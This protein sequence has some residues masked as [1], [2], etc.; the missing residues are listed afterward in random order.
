APLRLPSTSVFGLVL[1]HDAVDP[2]PVGLSLSASVGMDGTTDTA[3]DAGDALT[4]FR[5]YQYIQLGTHNR[6]CQGA[7]VTAYPDGDVSS[8]AGLFLNTAGLVTD[9]QAQSVVYV[10]ATAFVTATTGT[11]DGV[12]VM[13]APETAVLRDV[14]VVYD[15]TWNTMLSPS[16]PFPPLSAL[17]GVASLCHSDAALL[18]A[19]WS[20]S[21]YSGPSFATYSDPGVGPTELLFR[22]GSTYAGYEP[23]LVPLSPAD[24]PTSATVTVSLD[25]TLGSLFATR[26][27]VSLDRHVDQ[28]ALTLD[29]GMSVGSAEGISVVVSVCDG[30]GAIQQGLPVESVYPLVPSLNVDLFDPPLSVFEDHVVFDAASDP[31]LST[32][33]LPLSALVGEASTRLDGATSLEVQVS[34]ADG[35]TAYQAPHVFINH[36]TLVYIDE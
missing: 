24:G 2:I 10:L 5:G 15:Q 16:C 25:D 19:D 30:E 31:L 11:A 21:T 12:P 6:F 7:G 20:F 27:G 34:L 35:Y 26:Y 9:L 29:V 8:I 22:D 28:V 17:G 18:L 23:L 13:A 36:I 32:Y 4:P 1:G 14:R 33:T 3:P